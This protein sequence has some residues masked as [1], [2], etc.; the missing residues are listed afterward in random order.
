MIADFVTYLV[1][2]RSLSPQT[3]KFYSSDIAH[4]ERFLADPAAL[5]PVKTLEN[6]TT[7][8]IQS[9]IDYLSNRNYKPRSISRK[10]STLST[11][12]RYLVKKDKIT[13]SPIQYQTQRGGQLNVRKPVVRHETVSFLTPEQINA[14]IS[15]IETQIPLFG[16]RDR[17]LYAL[18]FKY[19]L[20][21]PELQ[22]ITL[23]DVELTRRIIKV[24]KRN[25]KKD[26]LVI[27]ND[28]YPYVESYYFA[29]LKSNPD[30]SDTASLFVNKNG[31]SISIRSIR[32]NL[33]RHAKNAGVHVNPSQL[34]HSFAIDKLRSGASIKQVSEQL[35]HRRISSVMPYINALAET[36]DLGPAAHVEV[37][38]VINEIA[39]DNQAVT[40]GV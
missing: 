26:E 14:L 28:L 38:P 33:T 2:Q 4:F 8:D 1:D 25:N 22:S 18:M 5:N 31:S 29:L 23:G 13:T 40:A 7:S 30:V 24:V 37:K 34:R 20:R 17:L 27:T 6:A 12:Y 10:V 11:F 21:A 9:Y 19:G 32:R 15:G 3:A 39:S 36:K 35:G 16:L